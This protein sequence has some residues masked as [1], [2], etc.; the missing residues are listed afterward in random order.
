MA[1][2]PAGVL[3]EG[4]FSSNKSATP[5]CQRYTSIGHHHPGNHRKKHHDHKSHLVRLLLP[6]TSRRILQGRYRQR[7]A[8]LKAQ[9]HPIL[10]CTASLKL[11]NGVQHYACSGRLCQPPVHNPEE[12]RQEGINWIQLHRPPPRVSSGVHASPSG[13]PSTPWQHQ[14]YA[15]LK[16]Q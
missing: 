11:R 4:G 10:H 2:T 12:R 6:P 16:V 1:R 3:S 14:R 15:S 8:P 9:V 5:P 7:P 13:I